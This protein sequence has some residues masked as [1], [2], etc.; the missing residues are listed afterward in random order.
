MR[1]ERELLK[2]RVLGPL[3]V[4]LGGRR[5][6]PPASRRSWALLGLLALTPGPRPRSVVAATLWPDVLDASAR[7]SLRSATWALRRALGPAAADRVV[8]T[9]DHLGVVDDDALGTDLQAFS[10]A[11]AAGRYEAAL[12]LCRGPL[13]EGID[14]EWALVER[15]ARPRRLCA[16]SSTA[17]PASTT[18]STTI[19]PRCASGCRCSRT[20]SAPSRRAACRSG[21]RGCSRATPR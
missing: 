4:E 8:A 9:R 1:A 15:D 6:P 7:A 2:I 12:E 10:A 13:L 18:S 11:V 16:R 3:E 5:V 19:R 17:A 21:W 14:D 20:C